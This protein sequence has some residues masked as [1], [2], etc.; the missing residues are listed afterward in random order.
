MIQFPIA[1]K[2]LLQE[3]LVKFGKLYIDL[4]KKNKLEKN[5]QQSNLM[6]QRIAALKMQGKQ[7]CF[8]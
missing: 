2:L 4:Q 5:I 6:C 1:A 7:V 8:E 3:K